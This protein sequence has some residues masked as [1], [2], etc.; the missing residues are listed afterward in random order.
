VAFG[1]SSF[2]RLVSGVGGFSAGL[3]IRDASPRLWS[4]ASPCTQSSLNHQSS[5]NQVNITQTNKQTSTHSS[6]P[7]H[8]VIEDT[9]LIAVMCVVVAVPS[10]LTNSYPTI[11]DSLPD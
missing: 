5:I 3:L 1:F 11:L 9:K 6:I 4:T 8:Q 2:L 7:L 10:R